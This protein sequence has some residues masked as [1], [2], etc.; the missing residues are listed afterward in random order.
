MTNSRLL[1]NVFLFLIAVS[2]IKNETGTSIIIP[3]DENKSD[4]IRIEGDPK[5]VQAAKTMLL[6]MA[7]KMVCEG[8]M[9]YWC[10]L[11]EGV[12]EACSNVRR[13][14]LKYLCIERRK[15]GCSCGSG[16]MESPDA[17]QRPFKEMYYH[18]G[19]NIATTSNPHVLCTPT[20][21]TPPPLRRR[22]TI[23]A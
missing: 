21:T 11:W 13:W 19:V 23:Q 9:E 18:P 22:I 10:G 16:G 14:K 15:E 1:L 8:G 4:V 7:A 5:G 12:C 2:R 6:D 3:P 20:T 17:A